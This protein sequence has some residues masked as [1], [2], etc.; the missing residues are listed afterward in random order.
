MST[1]LLMVIHVHIGAVVIVIVWYMDLQRPMQL[2]HITTKVVGATYMEEGP[3]NHWKFKY[4]DFILHILHSL[5]DKMLYSV[6]IHSKNNIPIL[7]DS[8]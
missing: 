3:I 6:H 1:F 5:F 7:Y 8:I 2:V 4:G